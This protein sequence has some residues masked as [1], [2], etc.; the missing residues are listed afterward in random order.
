[1]KRDERILPYPYAHPDR[2]YY[3]ARHAATGIPY[4]PYHCPRFRTLS[5][6]RAWVRE[7]IPARATRSKVHP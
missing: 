3:A 4:D 6:A 2:W 1:M 7:N 5:Q